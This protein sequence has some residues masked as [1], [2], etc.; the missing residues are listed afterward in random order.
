M[1]SCMSCAN[2]RLCYLFHKIQDALAGNVMLNLYQDGKTSGIHTDVYDAIG[3]A[4]REYKS[5]EI[6]GSD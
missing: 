2:I 5:R 3:D 6:D 4:C 1:R